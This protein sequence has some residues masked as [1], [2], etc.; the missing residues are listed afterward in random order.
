MT[1]SSPVVPNK[2]QSERVKD[3]REYL[4]DHP[5]ARLIDLEIFRDP[6]GGPRYILAKELKR[7]GMLIENPR[8][9]ALEFT[10]GAFQAQIRSVRAEPGLP[11]QDMPTV[12]PPEPSEAQE[13]PVEQLVKNEPMPAHTDAPVRVPE[14][15]ADVPEDVLPLQREW[16]VILQAI[17][18][19]QTREP[20]PILIQHGKTDPWHPWTNCQHNERIFTAGTLLNEIVFDFDTEDWSAI[21]Q[22]GDKLLTYLQKEGIPY[23]MGYS[24]GKGIHIH[25]FADFGSVKLDPDLAGHLEDRA[26][27]G[28]DVPV[29]VRRALYYHLV[30]QA[31]ADAQRAHLDPL[32]V[33][34]HK[35][36]KGSMMRAFGC[37]RP[38]G[39]KYAGGVKTLIDSI[40]TRR[41]VLGELPLRFPDE[42]KL[43]NIGSLSEIINNVLRTEISTAGKEAFTPRSVVGPLSSIPCYAYLMANGAPDGRRNEGAFTISLFN[44]VQ[45]RPLDEARTEVRAYS[46]ACPHPSPE[47]EREHQSTLDGVYKREYHGV[48]CNQIREKFKDVRP[49]ICDKKRCPLCIQ[50]KAASGGDGDKENAA[51]R[52][53]ELAKQGERA[54][55]FHDEAKA[56][57]ARIERDGHHEVKAIGEAD[58]TEWLNDLAVD[59][60]GLAPEDKALKRAVSTLKSY[61]KRGE[62]R[63]VF[64]RVG[65]H[66]G[67]FYIDKGDASW[68]A[69]KIT[70]DG[71]EEVDDPPVMFR[72]Y[73]DMLP[74][75]TPVRSQRGCGK[76]ADYTRLSH[77]DDKQRDVLAVQMVVLQVPGINQMGAGTLGL[78]GTGKTTNQR[79]LAAMGNPSTDVEA[80]LPEDLNNLDLHLAQHRMACFDNLSII[81][82]KQSDMLARGG[83][84]AVST[85][86][87]LYSDNTINRRVYTTP[88]F[89]NGITVTGAKPD[90]YD[91][92]I[93]YSTLDTW[94]SICYDEDAMAERIAE[95]LPCALGEVLDL[96]SKAMGLR[97]KFKAK[98]VRWAPRMKGWYLWALAVAE[99]MQ[100][101]GKG[102]EWFEDRFKP[103]MESRDYEAVAYHPLARAVE[104]VASQRGFVGTAGELYAHINDREMDIPFKCSIDTTDKNWPTGADSLGVKLAS[105]IVPLRSRDVFVYKFTWSRLSKHLK[106]IHGLER[107]KVS[108]EVKE[109]GRSERIIVISPV[110]LVFDKDDRGDE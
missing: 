74:H 9:G 23:I 1:N 25:V 37:L 57:Y 47:I 109:Y 85:R 21:K 39:E 16:L 62:E 106:V 86:R 55:F 91:R 33:G 56:P 87:A 78:G 75:V 53:V 13:K 90:F 84:G 101:E 46:A 5:G 32:K 65:E 26:D 44:R 38:K 108:V 93:I 60:E 97:D 54:E 22:E 103:M 105:L 69:F 14:A 79:L 50:A 58:F 7:R 82:E 71:W 73:P 107:A 104:Y 3:L 77:M 68:G 80:E 88:C 17:H 99:A 83:T 96:L 12:T 52:L 102:A 28:L 94:E 72:R 67:A 24:G 35:T 41:P 2:S 15:P 20:R 34:F 89:F 19:G 61:A 11:H 43:W 81:T 8:D 110:S 30:E 64:L 92:N 40:P 18:N 31:G 66:E 29:I 98:D 76:L 95:L 36:S 4:I 49:P 10:D 48:S 6:V 100:G 51:R 27:Y 59:A 45:G 63:E 42:V 70:E